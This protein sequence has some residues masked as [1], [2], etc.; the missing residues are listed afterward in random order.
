MDKPADLEALAHW[1]SQLRALS[2]DDWARV[3]ASLADQRG[4]SIQALW[5]RAA[6]RRLWVA[7]FTQRFQP[8]V[9]VAMA[10]GEIAR[11][12]RAPGSEP[13]WADGL[14]TLGDR[15]GKAVYGMTADIMEIVNSALP[16][17]AI[18]LEATQIAAVAIVNRAKLDTGAF[19]EAYAPFASVI[20]LEPD[21]S[22]NA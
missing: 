13:L 5:R 8:V 4:D 20:P 12:F 15:T 18:A 1:T 11:E 22:H 3:A 9:H 10:A 17:D 6:H 7:P 2:A 19:A 21:G 16:G 14:R